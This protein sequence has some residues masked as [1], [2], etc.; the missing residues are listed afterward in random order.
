MG[1][2]D[3]FSDIYASLSWTEA[4]AEA[5]DDN[6]ED[7]EDSEGGAEGGGDEDS[8]EKGGDEEEEEEEE[9]EPE[10]PKPKLEEGENCLSHGREMAANEMQNA[11]TPPCA[12]ALSTTSRSV[13]SA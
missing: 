12:L 3:L 7:S 5:A 13:W 10:D 9:E 6:K 11:P 4:H 8:E 2:S 1:L